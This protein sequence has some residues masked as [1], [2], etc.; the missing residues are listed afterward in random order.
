[1]W[2]SLSLSVCFQ[3]LSLLDHVYFIVQMHTRHT[4]RIIYQLKD[5]WVLVDFFF[6][7]YMKNIAMNIFLKDVLFKDFFV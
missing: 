1:M 3:G 5:F 2:S 7:T 6:Y 4:M